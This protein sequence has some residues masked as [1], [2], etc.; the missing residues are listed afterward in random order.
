MPSQAGELMER[1]RIRYDKIISD[2]TSRDI[3]LTKRVIKYPGCSAAVLFIK[4]LTQRQALANLII[5]PMAESCRETHITAKKT[6]ESIIYADDCKIETDEK[7]IATYILAGMAVILFSNDISYITVNLKQVEKRAI[8]KP[9]VTYTIRGPK[10]CFIEDLDTNISLIRYRIKNDKL[11]IKIQEV[12]DRTKT[13]VAV[14][15]I[16]DIADD[17]CVKE[18]KKRINNIS[19]DGILESGELQAFMLNR[20]SNLFPQMGLIER[21]DMAGGAL[22]EGKV[23]TIVDGSGWVLVAPKVFSEFMWSCEDF[24]D[25]KYLGVF[26]RVLRVIAL[27]LSLSLSSFY[28]GLVSFHNDILPSSYMIS[29]AETRVRVPFNAFVEVLLIEIIVEL[30]HESLIRVPTK[31]GTAIGIVGAIIIGQ[32]AVSAGV[33]SPL[34]LIIVSISLIASF[35]PTDYT[36][37]NPFRLLKFV[38]I[39]AT[40][41]FGF[42]GF[43]LVATVMLANLVS[44][45]T[46]GVPYMAPAAPYLK[47]DFKKSF[48]YNK[49]M[50]PMRPKFLRLKDKYRG[51]GNKNQKL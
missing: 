44:I 7:K 21:S 16:E 30:I 39:F 48:V 26:L 41:A 22:L 8:P 40:G 35:V 10:D 12:G 5:K 23:L 42:F 17:V 33:F 15:Y 11:R 45:N 46:F 36:I 43:T 49:T 51:T 14:V 13:R 18:V 2:L 20:K 6:I 31:I 37:M 29:I 9:E 38:F 24:Y 50:A 4:E 28:I 1:L 19:I 27:F 47:K 3:N 34:L 32:A 25:N